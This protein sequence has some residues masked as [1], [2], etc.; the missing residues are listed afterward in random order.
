MKHATATILLFAAASLVPPSARAWSLFG[1]SPESKLLARADEAYEAAMKASEAGNP[2]EELE[3]LCSARSAYQRL[4]DEYPAYRTDHV[5]QRL[6]A[7]AILI[8]DISSS[9][10]SG[11]SAIPDPASADA[12]AAEPGAPLAPPAAA[13]AP[14]APA[15][16][17]PI[18]V[19]VQTDAGEPA[20]APEPKPAVPEEDPSISAAIPN[21]FFHEAAAA[22]ADAPGT[23]G[24]ENAASVEVTLRETG[25]AA[26]V[27]PEEDLRNARIFL[28]MVREARATD[29][30]LLIEDRLEEEGDAASIRL[31]LMYA[32]ALVQ[33][34]NYRRAADVLKA[35]PAEAERD[36]AART[37]RAAVA[38]GTD[39][40]D[41]AVLQLSLLLS[42]H[43]DYADAYV[44]LAHVYAQLDPVNNRDVAIANYKAGLEHGAKR[45]AFLESELGIRVGR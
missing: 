15:F 14:D 5:S 10:E 1:S 28:D 24:G 45:D 29:A 20:S 44:D 42:E 35:L 40:L 37:L 30:V 26:A 22:P 9:I 16:R 2:L 27:P 12:R 33:C 39:N 8:S 31:R 43:A 32:R 3:S 23:P 7:A 25:P 13:P 6:N 38:V 18:P 36:P 11:E 21:P 4:S 17:T 34:R 19:L 41:E